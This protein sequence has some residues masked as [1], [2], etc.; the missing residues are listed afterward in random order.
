ME[1]QMFGWNLKETAASFLGTDIAAACHGALGPVSHGLTAGTKIAATLGWRDVDTLTEGDSV[2]TYHNAMQPIIKIERT[3]FW[4]KTRDVSKGQWPVTVPEGALGNRCDLV[5]LPDQGVMVDSDGVGTPQS[6]PVT[7]VPAQALVGVR[8]IHRSRPLQQIE[9][10]TLYFEN[11]EVIYTEGAFL[12]HCPRIEN[13]A[14]DADRDIMPLTKA[15]Q[16]V[17]EFNADAHVLA[18]RSAYVLGALRQPFSG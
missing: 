10:I 7:L 15:Q 5:L 12:V 8:G 11:D 13:S 4:S 3:V 17:K 6:A 1:T 18:S 9:V 16:L 2:L 14:E